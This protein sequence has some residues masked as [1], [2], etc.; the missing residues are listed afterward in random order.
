M[1]STIYHR[2][3][4]QVP[5][6]LITLLITTSFLLEKT[7]LYEFPLL[8]KAE[9]FLYDLRVIAT[10]QKDI[11]TRIVI[12][13]IDEKSL[14]EIGRWPWS[15]NKVAQLIDELFDNYKVS[16]VGFDI[17]FAEP[18]ESSGL[19]ILQELGKNEFNSLPEYHEVITG[20]EEQLDYDKVLAKSMSKHPVILGYY[21]NDSETAKHSNN[22]G[23]LPD[24]AFHKDVFANKNVFARQ[25]GGYGANLPELQSVAVSGGHFSPWL[26][27]DG[28][29]RRVPM[30]FEFQEN[31]YEALSLAMVKKLLNIKNTIPVFAEVDNSDYPSLEWLSLD[32][33][34]MIPVDQH[35]Q[36]LVP[37]RGYQGSFNYVSA[38][39]VI[40]GRVEKDILQDSIVLVG[41]TAPGLFDLR[42]TPVQKQYAGVEVHANLIAGILDQN[43]KLSPTYVDGVDF[44]QLFIIGVTLTLLLPLLSPLWATCITIMATLVITAINYSLWQYS[45]LVLPL[46]PS[47]FLIFILFVT[48]MSYGFF[49]ERRSKLQIA[50]K[51]GQYIPPEL[52]NEMNFDPESYTLEAE[53]RE[54]TVLFSD[55]RG[56]TTIS[57]N[58][59]PA[60]ISDLMNAYLTPMTK[61][62]HEN[63]G[64]IDKYIGDAIMAFWGAPIHNPEHA[65]FALKSALTMLEKLNAIRTEFTDRGW[66]NIYIGIG[67]HTG[68]M[69]V[70]NM[71]SEFRLSYTVLGDAVNLGSRLEALTKNYGVELIVSETTKQAVPEYV[72]R[73]LDI[74]TVKGKA[75]PV[76]IYEPIALNHEISQAELD[77]LTLLNVAIN[78]YRSQDWLKAEKIFQD[79]HQ[80][81]PDRDLYKIYLERIDNFKHSPPAKDW[82]GVFVHTSK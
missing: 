32:D 22:S 45:N 27:K 53:N 51:F 2:L 3:R 50:S 18:D 47:V 64:T 15:R 66:P 42:T 25:A 39:D 80:A 41:T 13:D 52:I 74:V 72:Y 20:L 56:F 43:I 79:L 59:S 63:R 65:R 71:G 36:A 57:E 8:D 67:L 4:H 73:E 9:N 23:M 44:I 6:I 37:Y 78:T 70:G 76:A 34:I 17:V 48:N 26:D 55:I 5:L 7:S 12:I 82:N 61:I 33:F 16:L 58:L 38:T 10:L 49:V 11:D 77:E 28:V 1:L 75:K 81:D 30:L 40:H 35:I 31:Y 68:T 46:A 69:S 24:P 60:E 21:F 14:A 54:M 19:K 62:I 29:I